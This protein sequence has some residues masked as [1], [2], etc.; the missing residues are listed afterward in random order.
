MSEKEL[1]PIPDVQFNDYFY[2]AVLVLVERE[3]MELPDGINFFPDYKIS[4]IDYLDILKKLM[5]LY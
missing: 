3:I 5:K 4:G 2:T 1:S